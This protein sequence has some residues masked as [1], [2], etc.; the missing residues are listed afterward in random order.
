MLS[1]L[2][3]SII[4]WSYQTTEGALHIIMSYCDGGDLHTLIKSRKNNLFQEHQILD[5]FVQI[6][7]GVEVS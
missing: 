3:L 5:Y 1:F 2:F 6:T 4:K 7:M